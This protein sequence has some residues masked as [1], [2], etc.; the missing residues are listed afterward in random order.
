MKSCIVVGGGLSG[1]TAAVY[2]SENKFKVTLLEASPKLGGRTYTLFNKEQDDW[3]DNG[4]HIMMGSYKETLL[5]LKKIGVHQKIFI[6][7]SLNI[8]FAEKNGAVSKL[9]APKFGYPLNLLIALL[10]YR[11]LSFKDR[12]KII[13]FFLNLLCCYQEDLRGVSVK[14]WLKKE[15]QSNEAVSKFWEILVVGSMNSS[16]EK[17]SAQIFHEILR[18]IFFNGNESAKII[19][20]MVGLTELFIEPVQN[21][22]KNLNVSINISERVLK[23]V[24]YNG[25]AV[26]IITD[27]NSYSDFDSIVFAV[28]PYALQKIEYEP[29]I[30]FKFPEFDYSPILNVHLWLSPNPFE[31]KFFSLIG[32]NIHWLFNHGAHISLT[33]SAADMFMESSNE[34][35]VNCFCSELELFFPIFNKKMVIDWKVIK[36]K[37]ATIVTDNSSDEKRKNFK[38]HFANLFF[39]GDWCDTGLPSTIEGAILSGKLAAQSVISFPER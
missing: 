4:Q 14:D 20:P 32:S 3:F 19:M 22:F 27:K 12:L 33:T 36:E 16:L 15:K 9:I 24:F 37:R 7:P 39:A 34:E 18:E 1:L 29:N 26:R 13:D 5:L 38:T 35:I 25:K 28:P 23:V 30:N 6:Q 2:L 8:S 11:S 17:A 21:F 31:E 10:K